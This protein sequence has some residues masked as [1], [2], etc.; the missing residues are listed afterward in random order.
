[1][2]AWESLI[3][4]CMGVIYASDTGT[5]CINAHLCKLKYGAG[6]DYAHFVRRYITRPLSKNEFTLVVSNIPCIVFTILS[7]FSMFLRNYM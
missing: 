5:K 3:Y 7:V 2:P 1:M 6:T 4:A